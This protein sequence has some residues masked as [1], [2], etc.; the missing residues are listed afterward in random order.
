MIR[1]LQTLNKTAVGLSNVDNTADSAKPVS[2]ATQ[3]SLNAK[4][5]LI[6]DSSNLIMN[7]CETETNL[8]LRVKSSNQTDLAN[9]IAFRNTGSYYNIALTRRYSAAL[10]N[11]TSNFCIQT[12]GNLI[13]LITYTIVCRI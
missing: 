4:Q 9:S 11:N 5:F 1:A 7:Y 13:V 3:S 10:G 12:G 6:T 8:V 2:T